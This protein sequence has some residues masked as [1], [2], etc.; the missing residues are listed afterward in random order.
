MYNNHI[1]N[2]IYIYIYIYIY[3]P[4]DLYYYIQWPVAPSPLL[5]AKELVKYYYMD[6]LSLKKIQSFV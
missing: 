3:I 6:L 5:V 4:L 2:F 1:T